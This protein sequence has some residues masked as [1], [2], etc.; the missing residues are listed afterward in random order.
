MLRFFITLIIYSFIL[1]P[2]FAQNQKRH[3]SK[4]YAEALARLKSNDSPAVSESST[5]DISI[6]Q[7][8]A[9]LKSIVDNMQSLLPAPLGMGMT[10]M[11]VTYQPFPQCVNY[12][13]DINNSIV[14]YDSFKDEIKKPYQRDI[15]L[16]S[17]VENDGVRLF[18]ES[19]YVANCP[20][21]VFYRF[22]ENGKTVSAS[23]SPAEIL[24]AWNKYHS[25]TNTI[26][27]SPRTANQTDDST[28]QFTTAAQRKDFSDIDLY[29]N[30]TKSMLPMTVDAT[31]ILTDIKRDGSSV[32]F[33]YDIIENTFTNK[34]LEKIKD[35]FKDQIASQLKS[36]TLSHVFLKSL[37]NND[38][39]L[40]YRYTGQSTNHTFDIVFSLDDIKD[41][42]K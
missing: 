12:Y 39:I 8:R 7:A 29:V 18:V 34:Q 23:Y 24:N 2:V 22:T 20:L 31:T 38:C 21:K 16:K 40:Y 10:F 5:I 15:F 17:F 14:K 27:P 36:N 25:G 41:I 37:V 3:S 35:V 19:V 42:L 9:N 28:N 30:T 4:K 32:T 33:Y 1:T 13:I 26:T 11:S 6:P